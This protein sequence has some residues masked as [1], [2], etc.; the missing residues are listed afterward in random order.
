[1]I[2]ALA[3]DAMMFAALAGISIRDVQTTFIDRSPRYKYM[4]VF[5]AKVDTPHS[6]AFV[7]HREMWSTLT[8]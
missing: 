5:Y 1:M 2:G 4:R 3:E 6:D 7:T 8:D